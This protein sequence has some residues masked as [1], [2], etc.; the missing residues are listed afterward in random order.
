L[1][2]PETA[3]SPNADDLNTLYW[4]L[5]VI[6]GV[7]VIAIN[8]ALIALAVRFRANRGREP[9]RIRSG[10]R[11]QG[12][13]LIGLTAV[14]VL[15]FLAGVINTHRASDV[16]SGGPQGLQAS[17]QRTAQRNISLPPASSPTLHVRASGQQWIWRYSY[18]DGTFSY[19][20]L[21]VPVDTPI[22]LQ[23]DSTHVVHRWWVPGLTGKFDAVPGQSDQ[24]WF[25]ADKE[26]TY[27]GASYQYSGASYAAM[28][29]QVDVVS[30]SE[31]EAWL[32]QQQAD[33]QEAQSFVQK[34][35]T[36]RGASGTESGSA[37]VQPLG[38]GQ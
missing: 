26:G 15:I 1:L 3:H 22:V 33:I 16:E 8:G 19:Y 28:R 18:P 21:V 17:S 12:G 11:V 32:K 20:D 38:A 30:V 37:D 13:S 27:Y 5:L 6:A 36:A 34:E 10:R 23:L 24:T 25:K 9:R 7:L 29:T 31:Y 35:V 14:A 4:V 2:G